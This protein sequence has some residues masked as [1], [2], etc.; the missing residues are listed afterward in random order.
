V[1]HVISCAFGDKELDELFVTTAWWGFSDE[2]RKQQPWAGD[3]FRVRTGVTGLVEPA[4][5]G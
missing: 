1:E 2:D 5:A 3:L 4:F